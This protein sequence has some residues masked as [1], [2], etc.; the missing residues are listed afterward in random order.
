[1]VVGIASSPNLWCLDLLRNA[2]GVLANINKFYLLIQDI[3]M[4]TMKDECINQF[5]EINKV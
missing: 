2:D 4:L 3:D 1:M 5:H